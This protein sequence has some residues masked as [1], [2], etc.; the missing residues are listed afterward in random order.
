MLHSQSNI[1]RFILTANIKKHH[2]LTGHPQVIGPPRPVLAFVGD[3]IILP[4]HLQ[5]ATD[6]ASTAVEWTRPDLKP[7]FVHLWRSGQELLGD[8]HPSYLGRTSLFT[9]KLKHGDIS[10]K[11]SRVKLS[12]KG[13]Y[14]CYIPTM[15]IDS[16]V[17]L[18]F[19]EWARLLLHLFIHSQVNP[20]LEPETCCHLVYE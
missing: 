7:R 19:G 13:T 11:L 5:P 6:V 8:Q 14:R 12:D 9:N 10:L 4:C 17:K 1:T 3:D 18:V 20:A 16:T 15:N 2:S